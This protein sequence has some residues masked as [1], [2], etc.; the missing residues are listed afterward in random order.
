MEGNIG[1]PEGSFQFTSSSVQTEISQLL[2]G[3]LQ[4]GTNIHGLNFNLTIHISL[5]Y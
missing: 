4:L 1:L 2:D 3:L 5:A